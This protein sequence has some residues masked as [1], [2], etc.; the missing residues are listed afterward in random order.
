MSNRIALG[1]LFLFAF[2]SFAEAQF[3]NPGNNQWYELGEGV[4][5]I[6]RARSDAAY[7]GGFLVTINDVAEESW[8]LAN[9]LGE[10]LLLL[11]LSDEITEGEY[12]WDSGEPVTYNNVFP[13]ANNDFNDYVR[14]GDFGAWSPM[15]SMQRGQAVV[16][17]DQPLPARVSDF[18]C[19]PEG[20]NLRLDW[21]NGTSYDQLE[22]RRDDVVIATIPGGETTYLDT[23]PT[24]PVPTYSVSGLAS[25]LKSY[26]VYCSSYAVD[27]TLELRLVDSTIEIGQVVSVPLLLTAPEGENVISM[28]YH[29]RHDPSLLEIEEVLPGAAVLAQPDF[30]GMMNLLVDGDTLTV[31]YVFIDFFG[32]HPLP[33]GEELEVA[34]VRYRAV[35]AAPTTVTLEALNL[36][37]IFFP[38][39]GVPGHHLPM[40]PPAQIE[41]VERPYV[42]GDCSDD[43]LFN[44]A[45]PIAG[46][47]YLFLS[48]ETP[49]CLRACDSN[50][51]GAI[52]IADTIFSLIYLFESA[53]SP[54]PTPFPECGVEVSEIECAQ[55][56]ACP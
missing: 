55:T 45:D 42:R 30:P 47:G 15:N 40:T 12:L 18:H 34:V 49:N 8:I 44:I 21:T 50:G 27:P 31:S 7:V 56:T 35:A 2:P 20:L 11:G 13:G 32:N 6:D 4:V 43:G 16:E 1:F 24:Y 3:L 28:G 54:P 23:S 36:P 48:E 14:M 52:D 38:F 46:A 17:T 9:L 33:P 29:V 41:I 53:A 51:D 19:E 22:I 25:G 10:E 26:P 37:P 39:I 5:G